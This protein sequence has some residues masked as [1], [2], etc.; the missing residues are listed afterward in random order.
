MKK[1]QYKT[2][3]YPKTT[4]FCKCCV[5]MMVFA[6]LYSTTAIASPITTTPPP[7]PMPYSFGVSP[8]S[9][10]VYISP[11]DSAPRHSL[12]TAAVNT[13]LNVVQAVQMTQP[14]AT[15]RQVGTHGLSQGDFIGRLHVPRLGRTINIFE[16]ETMANM[17]FGA[18]RF[19]FSGL[20]YGNT[21]L[22]GHN[23]GRTNGFFDF[24]RHLR[25]GDTLRLETDWGTREY[26]V[27]DMLIVRENDFS[28]AMDFFD[29]RLSLVTCVEYRAAYRRVAVAIAVN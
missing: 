9:Q 28:W 25:E 5:L 29:T 3:G 8:N 1:I 13:S 26:V 14:Q 18:G 6:M 16:G 10:Q 20:N 21:A 22:I 27:V 19:S 24:V 7:T 23:R 15:A 11:R 2:K 12:N 4:T 17:D